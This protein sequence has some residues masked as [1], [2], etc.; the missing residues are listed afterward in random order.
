MQPES[1]PAQRLRLRMLTAAALT[2]CVTGAVTVPPA[3]AGALNPD[4]R[5]ERVGRGVPNAIGI[6]PVPGQ[7][8][9]LVGQRDGTLRLVAGDGLGGEILTRLTVSQTCAGEGLMGM[10]WHPA[11][12]GIALYVT[13]VQQTPRRLTVARLILDGLTVTSGPEILFQTAASAACNNIG[14]G[15]AFGTDGTFFLGVGD[16]GN[17]SATGPGQPTSTVGKIMRLNDDG[18]IPASGNLIGGSANFAFGVRNPTRLVTDFTNGFSYFL[19]L[20]PGDDDELNL[21]ES[22]NFGWPT[23]TGTLNNEPTTLD[24]MVVWSPAA[25]PTGLTIADADHFGPSFNGDPVVAIAAAGRILHADTDGAGTLLTQSTLYSNLPGEPAGFL[26]AVSDGEGYIYLLAANGDVHR[27]RT[28]VGNPTEPS[29]SSSFVPLTVGKAAGGN[30]E[31]AVEKKTGATEYGI[32]FGNNSTLTTDGWTHGDACADAGLTPPC[33]NRYLLSTDSASPSADAYARFELKSDNPACQPGESAGSTCPPDPGYEAF[34]LFVSAQNRRLETTLGLEQ[35][36]ADD[37]I[38][39]GNHEF[40]CRCDGNIGNQVGQCSPD[41]TLA[42]GYMGATN[43]ILTPLVWSEYADCKVTLFDYSMEWC[44]PCRV[45]AADMEARYQR[46]KD[47]GFDVVYVIGEDWNGNPATLATTLSWT[48][49]FG[50]TVP[51]LVEEGGRVWNLYNQC[52]CIPQMYLVNDQG[53]ITDYWNG[54]DA[55]TIDAAIERE[56]RAAGR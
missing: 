45:H 2:V 1:R 19:D 54:I 49:D 9:A 12:Q 4:H 37:P 18:T 20:G 13:Y 50:L 52:N 39:G 21:L 26:D 25:V 42:Q 16:Q 27:L 36:T 17:S 53:V 38:P 30:L 48:Q 46:N 44:G 3:Q 41:F 56:L 14:G 23:G 6:L 5:F 32:Y 33:A 11:A 31:I 29:S 47:R 8:R 43:P 34:Y 28:D 55:A 7:S 35:G 40:T 10:T 22:G 24:P 15:I 51:V